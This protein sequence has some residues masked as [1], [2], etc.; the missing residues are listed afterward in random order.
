MENTMDIVQ[1][2]QGGTLV[3]MTRGQAIALGLTIIAVVA[4]CTYAGYKYGLDKAT[5]ESGVISDILKA[6]AAM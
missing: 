4:G 3:T 5:A 1:V 6:Y 2:Q